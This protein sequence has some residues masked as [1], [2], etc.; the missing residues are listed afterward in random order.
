[1][2]TLNLAAFCGQHDIRGWMNQ[3]IIVDDSWSANPWV[4]VVEFKRVTP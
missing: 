3:P 4:W 2:T 1:M